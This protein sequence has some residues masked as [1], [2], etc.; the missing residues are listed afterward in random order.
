MKMTNNN[1]HNSTGN[2]RDEYARLLDI[3]H[4]SRAVDIFGDKISSQKVKNIFRIGFI[5]NHGVPSFNNHENIVYKND[6]G[7]ASRHDGSGRS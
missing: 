2:T 7:S 3:E 4:N 1:C 6:G 5:N